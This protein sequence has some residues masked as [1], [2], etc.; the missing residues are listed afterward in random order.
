MTTELPLP[1]Q[2]PF[3]RGP[4][5]VTRLESPTT[6]VRIDGRFSL[7]W[8]GRLTREQLDLV[9]IL[10]ARRNNLQQLATDLGLSYNTVRARFDEIVAAL[11]GDV[12]PPPKAKPAADRLDVLRRLAAGDLD[13]DAAEAALRP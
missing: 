13:A 8:M 6:G 10:L 7:G 5:V 3:G 11:G 1:V 4:L 9:G 2:D 12:D